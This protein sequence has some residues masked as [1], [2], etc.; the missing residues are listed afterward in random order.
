MK[1]IISVLLMLFSF[2]VYAGTVQDVEK[3]E[4]EGSVSKSWVMDIL[5]KGNADNVVFMDARPMSFYNKQHTDTIGHL[6]P[7]IFY[8]DGGC[9]KALSLIPKDK[10]VVLICPG[11]RAQESYQNITDSAANG[12]CGYTGGNVYWI[13]TNVLY[14]KD[15]IEVK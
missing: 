14:H 5:K 9:E 6:D 7:D 3:G 11:P 8:E 12:G 2:A 13:R 15:H 4:Q 10:I 1:Q